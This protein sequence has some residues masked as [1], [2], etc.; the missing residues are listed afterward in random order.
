MKENL[1]SNRSFTL[2]LACASLWD[3]A[4]TPAYPIDAQWSIRQVRHL[5]ITLEIT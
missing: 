2:T 4:L 5:M 3:S 1:K